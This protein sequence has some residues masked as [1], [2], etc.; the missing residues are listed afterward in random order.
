MA[1]EDFRRRVKLSDVQKIVPTLIVTPPEQNSGIKPNK[2]PRM[3]YDLASDSVRM[4]EELLRREEE[5]LIAIEK[6]VREEINV[7]RKELLSRESK[8]KELEARLA[9]EEGRVGIAK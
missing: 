6:R 1:L 5:K 9:R 2:V 3:P 4:K 8:L 7:K